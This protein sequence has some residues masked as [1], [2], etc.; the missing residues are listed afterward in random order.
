MPIPDFQSLMLPLLRLAAEGEVRVSEAVDRLAD[1]FKLSPE[2]RSYLLPSTND[3]GKSRALGEELSRQSGTD[4]TD[5]PR[6][7][8]HHGVAAAKCWLRHPS[9]STSNF[10]AAFLSFRN[11]ERRK[12]NAEMKQKP[13]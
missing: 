8:S 1:D 9:V 3:F 7:L 5:S 6:T 11:S 2:D 13:P 12:V 4:R 10:S